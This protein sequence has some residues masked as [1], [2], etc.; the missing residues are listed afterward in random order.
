MRSS[1]RFSKGLFTAPMLAVAVLGLG[2]CGPDYALFRVD[3][4]SSYTSRE[5]IEE[6]RMTITDEKGVPVLDNYVL[7]TVAGDPNDTS[8]T[9]S[10]GCGGGITG[11]KIGRFSYSSS[12]TSGT[13]TFQVDAWDNHGLS[14]GWVV[15]APPCVPVQ[16][17]SSGAIAPKAFPPEVQVTV[18]T[19]VPK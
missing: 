8:G 15:G 17:G 10:Q 13:L 9:L 11:Q 6:C 1:T 2:A 14:C 4:T 7:G 19:D 18:L 16:S 12:R 5:K 3:I